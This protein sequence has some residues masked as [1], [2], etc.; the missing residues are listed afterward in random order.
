VGLRL[1]QVLPYKLFGRAGISYSKNDFNT[2]R[3]DDNYRGEVLLRYQIQQWLFTS[4]E[5]RY[6]K[7]DSSEADLSFTDHQ[8]MLTLGSTY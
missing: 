6:W 4:A 7:K 2:E 3:D 1:D 8:V 5:Y